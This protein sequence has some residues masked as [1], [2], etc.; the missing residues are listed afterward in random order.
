[1]R[2]SG[3]LRRITMRNTPDQ[4]ISLTDPDTRSMATA[5]ADRV[6]SG[7][8]VQVAVDTATPSDC[9]ARGHKCR[10]TTAAR[11]SYP[12]AHNQ[13]PERTYRDPAPRKEK[14]RLVPG[15]RS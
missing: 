11:R 14:R 1:M 6:S 5:D 10:P 3:G 12:F 4:Q 15:G 8:N 13:D 9:Y 2:Q 7:Y